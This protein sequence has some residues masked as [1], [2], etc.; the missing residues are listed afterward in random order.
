MVFRMKTCLE[1]SIREAGILSDFSRYAGD[2]FTPISTQFL[3]APQF[4]ESRAVKIAPCNVEPYLYKDLLANDK[5]FEIGVNGVGEFDRGLRRILRTTETCLQRFQARP[6]QPTFA[7]L[8]SMIGLLAALPFKRVAC[9]PK[10]IEYCRFS[11]QLPS[12]PSTIFVA[13]PG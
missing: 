8:V 5:L 7:C 10:I 13:L 6:T 9:S 2:F 12:T 1:M 4:L 3:C 11:L